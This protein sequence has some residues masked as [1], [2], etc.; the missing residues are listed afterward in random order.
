MRSQ[1]AQAQRGPQAF[2]EAGVMNGI[3][4][5]PKRVTLNLQPYEVQI[6]QRALAALQEK[7]KGRWAKRL[8]GQYW[9]EPLPENKR[10]K[11]VQ[12]DIARQLNG[13]P[14]ALERWHP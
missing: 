10:I 9:Y 6:I 8:D 5:I 2:G 1:E 7:I 14:E 11:F 3:E 12:G 13:I 4:N